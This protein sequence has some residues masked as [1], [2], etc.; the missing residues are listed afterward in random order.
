[1][2]K[3]EEIIYVG[4]PMCSWCWGFAPEFQKLRTYLE[5]HVRFAFCAG[6]CETATSGTRRSGMF[7]RCIGM[8]Y[9]Q[10]PG[11]PSITIS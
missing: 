10:E 9:R 4:D 11:S 5:P 1:M 2:H 8:K 7:S 6:A 3:I